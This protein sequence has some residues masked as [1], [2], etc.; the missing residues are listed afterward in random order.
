M[1]RMINTR[2]VKHCTCICL[3]ILY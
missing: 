3:S 2:N 1:S